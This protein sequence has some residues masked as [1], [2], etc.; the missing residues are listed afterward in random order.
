MLSEGSSARA[1]KDSRHQRQPS[2]LVVKRFAAQLVVKNTVERDCVTHSCLPS[3]STSLRT[4]WPLC[5]ATNCHVVTHPSRSR[6]AS[7]STTQGCLTFL[8]AWYPGAKAAC[9]KL[10]QTS[11]CTHSSSSCSPSLTSTG[12]ARRWR[13]R[14]SDQEFLSTW[15]KYL[16]KM[17]FF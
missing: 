7:P 6:L 11:V 3:E 2:G 1:V 12:R 5:S 10:S 15:T 16:L 13:L 17:Q 9:S 8:R 4:T 14:R